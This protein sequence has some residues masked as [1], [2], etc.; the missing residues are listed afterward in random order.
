MKCKETQEKLKVNNNLIK[1]ENK[2]SYK[3]LG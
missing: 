3:R 2:K 1:N